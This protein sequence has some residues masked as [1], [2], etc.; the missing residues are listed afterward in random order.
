MLLSN[1]FLLFMNDK[2][3]AFLTSAHPPLDDRIFYH[4]AKSLSGEYKT[5][6]VAST[7]DLK[8]VADNVTIIS[9]DCENWEKKKKIDFFVD[10]LNQTMPQIIVCSEPLPILAAAKYRKNNKSKASILYDVTEWYPSKKNLGYL[11][12]FSKI[13]SFIKLLVFNIYTSVFCN[14]FIFGE[15]YKSLPFRMLFPFKKWRIIGYST[16]LEY[17]KYRESTLTPNKICLGYTGKISVEKGIVNVFNVARS[18]KKKKPETEIRLK[19]IGWFFDARDRAIFEKLCSESKDLNIEIL[20]KQK[21]E[22]FSEQLADID[23]LFDLRKTDFENNHCL[24]IKIFYYAACGKPIIYS[25]LKAIKRDIDVAES[26]YLVNP[27]ESDKIADYLVEYL[28]HPDLYKRHSLN[29]RRLAEEKYNWKLQQ[30]DFI[31]FISKFQR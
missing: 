14:G 9:K 7:E 8:T 2:I 20:G 16:N 11:P 6:I 24:P 22:S 21:Y 10:V 1:S 5:V 3:I 15:Y 19:I 4:Q 12:F 30:I 13:I 26:G 23:V 28:E 29:G 27:T 17:I 25:N 31:D 18:L